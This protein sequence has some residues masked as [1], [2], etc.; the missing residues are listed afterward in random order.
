MGGLYV[1]REDYVVK[2]QTW[3]DALQTESTRPNEKQLLVL[4]AVRDRVL[5]EI[6]LD[7]VGPSYVAGDSVF[8][9][10]VLFYGIPTPPSPPPWYNGVVVPRPPTPHP[11]SAHSS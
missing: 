5:Q 6:E 11:R 9:Y 1:R 10:R 2:F 4:E 7:I 3:F 8:F